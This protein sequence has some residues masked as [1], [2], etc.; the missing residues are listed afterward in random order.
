MCGILYLLHVYMQHMYY[1]CI[2]THNTYVGY[3]LVLHV[4]HVYYMHYTH[5]LHMYELHV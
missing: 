4:K 3:T 1:T 2:P 5:V